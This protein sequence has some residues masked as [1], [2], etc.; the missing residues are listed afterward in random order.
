[1]ASQGRNIQEHLLFDFEKIQRVPFS[2]DDCRLQSVITAVTQH[3]EL[4]ALLDYQQPLSSQEVQ[5]RLGLGKS[6][7]HRAL[8]RLT[9]IGVVKRV[10]FEHHHLYVVNSEHNRLIHSLLK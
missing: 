10:C 2:A 8:K 3:I 5:D 4:L 7:V 9:N 6:T 1:M